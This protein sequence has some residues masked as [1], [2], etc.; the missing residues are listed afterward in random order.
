MA[1]VADQSVQ[2]GNTIYLMIEQTPIGR[3]QSLSAERSFGTEGVYEIGSIMPQEHVFLKYTGTVSLERYRMKKQS[4]ATLGFA[5]LG[6][7]VL[8]IDIID[9]VTVDNLTNEVIIAYRGCSISQY[10]ENY[11]ANEITTESS[12]FYYLTS[13]AVQSAQGVAQGN[14]SNAPGV[15]YYH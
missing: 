14:N 11:R 8:N 3:A 6:E 4:L 10:S 15:G 7:E 5:A 1:R 9:I 2:T 13:T 12:Q